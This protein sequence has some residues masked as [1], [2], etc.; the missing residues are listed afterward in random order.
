VR[1]SFSVNLEL[2]QGTQGEPATGQVLSGSVKHFSS[3]DVGPEGD[4]FQ[5]CVDA[6]VIC[7]RRASSP[8]DVV[9]KQASISIRYCDQHR[10]A[11]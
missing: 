8:L 4:L 5:P 11:V 3:G 1:T 9:F 10:D 7:R 6:I 2:K